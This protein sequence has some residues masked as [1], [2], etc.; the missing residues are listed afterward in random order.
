MDQ[1]PSKIQIIEETNGVGQEA[2]TNNIP[3]IFVSSPIR[4]DDSTTPLSSAPSSTV[5]SISEGTLDSDFSLTQESP[6]VIENIDIK[7]ILTKDF[8]G[9]ALLQKGLSNTLT[10]SDRDRICDILVTSFVNTFKGKLNR[11]HFDILSQKLIQIF[12]NEKKS[13]YFINPILKKNSTRN[14]SEPARGKLGKK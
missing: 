14:K 4:A 7:S 13:T 12:P 1:P 11:H 3:I 8:I 6:V 10:N 2:P 9:H 5:A